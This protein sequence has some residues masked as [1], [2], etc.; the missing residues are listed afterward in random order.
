MA[1][2]FYL[3]VVNSETNAFMSHVK[4]NNP[5]MLNAMKEHAEKV[6]KMFHKPMKVRRCVRIKNNWKLV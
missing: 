3:V 1:L 6:S 5:K 4:P 2:T